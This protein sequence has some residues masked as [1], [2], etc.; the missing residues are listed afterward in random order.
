MIHR[1]ETVGVIRVPDKYCRGHV[2]RN[3]GE[4]VVSALERH[5]LGLLETRLA[6]RAVRT[7]ADDLAV[8]HGET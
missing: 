6:I 4:S 2:G 8:F 1:F 5:G 3:V 7:G